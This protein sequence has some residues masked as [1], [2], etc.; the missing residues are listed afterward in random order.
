MQIAWEIFYCTLFALL[1]VS[2][3]VGRTDPTVILADSHRIPSSVPKNLDIE[4]LLVKGKVQT[5]QPTCDRI[6]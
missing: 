3:F 6:Q 5:E 2:F 1:S 4:H